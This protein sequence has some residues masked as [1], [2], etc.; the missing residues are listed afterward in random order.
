MMRFDA[1]FFGGMFL[2]AAL[3]IVLVTLWGMI[4]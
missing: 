4:P 2:G 3:V 1:E